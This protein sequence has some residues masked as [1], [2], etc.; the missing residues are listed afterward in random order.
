MIDGSQVR[1]CKQGG[2][3]SYDV[4]QKSEDFPEEM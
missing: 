2:I 3:S 1:H 4:Q